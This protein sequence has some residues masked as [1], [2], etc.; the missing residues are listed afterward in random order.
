MNESRIRT[1]IETIEN[2][3]E[4][5]KEKQLNIKKHIE[6]NNEIYNNYK[7]ENA[8]L[9]MEKFTQGLDAPGVQTPD[10][11]ESKDIERQ[12]E[13]ELFEGQLE[14]YDNLIRYEE[15]KLNNI[16]KQYRIIIDAERMLKNNTDASPALLEALAVESKKAKNTILSILGDNKSIVTETEKDLIETKTNVT[17]A[18]LLNQVNDMLGNKENLNNNNETQKLNAAFERAMQEDTSSIGTESKFAFEETED[19]YYEPEKPEKGLL[20]E[21]LEEEQQLQ[22]EQEKI[23][24]ESGY[25]K[26]WKEAKNFFAGKKSWLKLAG[27]TAGAVAAIA[28]IAG[29]M[30][31]LI[32]QIVQV[33][34]IGGIGYMAGKYGKK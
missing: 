12:A 3:I 29:P 15:E 32:P 20:E 24:E 27:L 4:K 11:V 19:G 13:V 8:M 21:K 6:E 17:T 5:L 10:V 23:A 1:E 9:R 33:A 2:R 14:D 16:N 30:G 26:T 22:E 34:E 7:L 31:A 28:L 18:S 25:R